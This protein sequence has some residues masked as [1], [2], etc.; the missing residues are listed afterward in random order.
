MRT[1]NSPSPVPLLLLPTK[2]GRYYWRL[3]DD[4]GEDDCASIA[5]RHRNEPI[6]LALPAEDV[7]L[8]RLALAPNER[9]HATQSVP[10]TLEEELSEELTLLHVA[11]APPATDSV[12]AAIVRRS[13]LNEHLQ[14]LLQAQLSPTLCVPAQ[15][16]LRRPEHG[17]GAA[18]WMQ[19]LV[20][21]SASGQ[22]CVCHA[23]NATELLELLAAEATPQC[24]QLH[25]EDS[26]RD[27]V[28]AW[29][30]PQLQ[31]CI[32]VIS[33]NGAIPN[34]ASEA[35]S[36][37][38]IVNLLQGAFKPPISWAQLWSKWRVTAALFIGNVLLY[39]LIAH[40]DVRQL[41]QESDQLGTA[42]AAVHRE[43]FDAEERRPQKAREA[44]ESIAS[45][46]GDGKAQHSYVLPLLERVAAVLRE[47]P[48][49]RL[50]AMQYRIEQPQTLQVEIEVAGFS[51]VDTIRQLFEQHGLKAQMLGSNALRNKRVRARFLCNIVGSSQ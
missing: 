41:Q 31:T 21:H 3:A 15:Q 51:N 7:L 29:F 32:E 24:I 23:A 36:A 50:H 34:V 28:I 5:A 42:I 10:Y 48:T 14:Q 45:S 37:R 49:S 2:R 25:V 11:L 47:Q 35:L 12:V 39:S 19:Q 16:L 18:A 43:F 26:Q 20:V 6:V 30:P 4:S 13:L 44:F 22:S 17:W 1:L 27:A 9:S 33:S 8:R 40:G 38:D 46:A